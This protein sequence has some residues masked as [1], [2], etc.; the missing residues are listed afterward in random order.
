MGAALIESITCQ[1]N[2]IKPK[3]GANKH[4]KRAYLALKKAS[5]QSLRLA[6]K[7]GMQ[8]RL[9]ARMKIAVI[10]KTGVNQQNVN[11]A[12]RLSQET[13]NEI[14]EFFFNPEVSRE[15]P[16]KGAALK[17]QHD[18]YT[19]MLMNYTNCSCRIFYFQ[20]IAP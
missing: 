3:G 4:Q 17:V 18:L 8:S 20:E 16:D 12:D 10:R 13:R 14:R 6:E 2:E 19:E 11:Y 9:R 1:M 5:L 7:R 15:V